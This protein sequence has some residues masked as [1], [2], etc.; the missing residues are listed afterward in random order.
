MDFKTKAEQAGVEFIDKGNGHIQLKGPLLVNYYPNSKTR[1]AY[2][3]GTSK[4]VKHVTPDQAI[5]MCFEAPQGRI[6]TKRQQSYRKEKQ[7]LLKRSSLCHWCQCKLNMDTATLDHKIPI[8]RGGLN[9]FNNYVLAC[10]PC[11]SKRGNSMPE[12]ERSDLI[13]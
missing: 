9:N 12:V 7:A 4:G 8:S 5:Q 13:G 10:E 3:A 2:V 6:K 1:T 11:N